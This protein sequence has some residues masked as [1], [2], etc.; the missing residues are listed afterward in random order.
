MSS[1]YKHKRDSKKLAEI[2]RSMEK[3]YDEILRMGK[4]ITNH[5][6]SYELDPLPNLYNFPESQ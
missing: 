6:Y 2:N 1:M 3:A 5:Q 4:I